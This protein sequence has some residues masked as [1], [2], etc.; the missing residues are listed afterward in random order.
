MHPFERLLVS[1]SRAAVFV[2]LVL[3]SNLTSRAAPLVVRVPI[4]ALNSA[5]NVLIID[6]PRFN[7]KAT[8]KM[9]VTHNYGT[10]GARQDSPIGV[11]Y[12][13][14]P[15]NRWRILNENGA[16]MT[17][18]GDN[19]FNILVSSAAARVNASTANS[20]SAT[21]FFTLKKGKPDA[22]LL[23]THVINPFP[24]KANG[25][26]LRDHFGVFYITGP[27]NP[28]TDVWSVI[29]EEINPAPAAAFNV[30]DATTVVHSIV[31]TATVANIA[32]NATKIDDPVA[33]G[34]AGAVV[35]VT[36]VANPPGA[37]NNFV[38][39]AIGV[40]YDGSNWN[41]YTEDGTAFPPNTTYNLAIFSGTTP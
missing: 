39:K 9:I 21:T 14:A 24:K 20:S 11:Q 7:G 17:V 23:V 31:H 16:A 6:D 22:R 28:T 37:A 27:G 4:T 36:H 32:S 10:T 40:Y 35:F 1:V 2:A 30:F 15:T 3:A 38:A 8:L 41:V 18:T 13:G 33:N 5:G 29:D 34:N 25:M 12:F 26:N 19:S